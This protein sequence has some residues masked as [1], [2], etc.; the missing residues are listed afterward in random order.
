MEAELGLRKRGILKPG[1]R[2][3]LGMDRISLEDPPSTLQEID[4]GFSAS[5]SL[6]SSSGSAFEVAR[7]LLDL[8]QSCE[9]SLG[10]AGDSAPPPSVDAASVGS[11][12]Y[13]GPGPPGGSHFAGL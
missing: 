10:V 3:D 8:G 5:V 11:I 12:L 7:S 2:L 13:V 6:P 4:L 9:L 1:R